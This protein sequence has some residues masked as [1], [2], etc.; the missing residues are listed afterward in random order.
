MS[1]SRN[2]PYN[3]HNVL[4]NFVKKEALN[5]NHETM[6]AADY[7]KSLAKD[8]HATVVSTVDGDNKP[9]SRIIDTL[10]PKD[11]K[12][13]FTTG[14]TKDFYAQLQD[15][16]NLAMTGLKG[17]ETLSSFAI[18]VNGKVRDAGT[19]LMP[20]IFEAYPY[21]NSIYPT[22]EKKALLRVMEVYTGTVSIYDLRETP[23]Y[24]NTLPF[25]DEA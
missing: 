3:N 15:N 23:I 13:Y 22:P 12:L 14:K 16:P 24:Q 9:Q 20:E 8:I 1:N 21:L 11:G 17:E 6:T 10:F 4:L 18:T 5:M 25:G 2:K 7:L 19:A